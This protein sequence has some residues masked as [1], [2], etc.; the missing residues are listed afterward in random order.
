MYVDGEELR[1]LDEEVRGQRPAVVLDE[2]EVARRDADLV[3]ELD[4]RE[5]F[6]PAQRPDFPAELRAVLRPL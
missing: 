3:R 5:T 6:A 4:L 1:E 2:V